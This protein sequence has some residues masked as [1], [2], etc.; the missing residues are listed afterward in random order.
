MDATADELI[1]RLRRNPDDAAAYNALRVHYHRLGDF[2]SL[3][4]L[5]EG[6]AGRT[7]DTTSAG[8][9][10]FEAGELSWGALRDQGRGM[11][12]YE[13]ALE[14]NGAHPDAF[15]RLSSL[16]EAS[17]D[18]Q[19]LAE[20]IERRADALARASADPREVAALHHRLGELWEHTFQRADKAIL[21]YRRAFELD[22]TLVPAIYA[23]REIYR[24]A[25]NLKAVATLCELEVKAEPDVE[26]RIAL[27]RELAHL[28]LES[29][30]DAEGAVTA[31]K[32]A[33][34]LD[35]GNVEVQLDLTRV[36]LAR[37]ERAQDPHLAEA[38]RRRAADALFQIAAKQPPNEAVPTLEQALDAAPD[39]EQA[40]S[41]LER[42]AER[43]GHFEL[44]PPR[45]VAFLARAAESPTAR[46]R[47]KRLAAAYAD[48]G[49]L[50]YAAQCYEWLLEEGDPEAADALVDLYRQLGRDADV[51]RA[52][53]AAARTLPPNARVPRLR[54]MMAIAIASGDPGAA[55]AHARGILEVDASDPEAFTYLETDLKK[56][57]AWGELKDLLL[58]AVRVPG[59]STDAR[60][61]RLRE[62]AQIAE[63][64]MTDVDA[65]IHAHQGI[66][67]LDPA[68][69]D[70]RTALLR[71]FEQAQRWD[72]LAQALEREVA[73]R[74]DTASQID[75][76]RRLAHVHR[77]LRSDADE[78]ISALRALRA[79]APT[80]TV[81]R[82]SLCDLLV[83]REEDQDAIPL[84]EERVGSAPAGADR[85]GLRRTLAVALERVGE[86]ERAFEAWTAL[87]GDDPKDFAALDR[88]VTIDQRSGNAERLLSTL[89]YRADLESGAERAMTLR[90]MGDIADAE[91]RDLDRAA[92]LYAR[93]LELAPSDE[94]LLDALSSAYD[95]AERY[96]DLVVLLRDRARRES[97]PSSRAALYR[98]I[99]RTL[100]D[101]VQNDDGAAEA[102]QEVLTAGEDVEA[103]SFLRDRAR[104][105]GDVEAVSGFLDRL[106]RIAEDPNERRDLLLER[107]TLVAE[108]LGRPH[109]A[110][111]IL[112]IVVREVDPSHLPALG[113]LGDLTEAV[114]DWA[115][116]AE[117]LERTLGVL[118]DPGLRVPVAQRLADLAEGE[119][120][121]R[122]RAIAA[123][124]QWSEADLMDPVPVRRLVP[125]LEAEE[126]WAPLVAALDQLAELEE[127]DAAISAVVLRAVE[128]SYRKLG[129]VDRS[130]GRL[131]PRVALGDSAA[132][133]SLRELARA[134]GRGEGLVELYV[135]LAEDSSDP[136]EQQ[137]R[138]ADAA[139]VEEQYLGRPKEALELTLKAF[140]AD[141]SE[142]KYLDEADRLSGLAGDYV[143]LGQVYETLV[144]RAE[145]KDTKVR[146]LVRHAHVLEEK[147]GD[148]GAALDRV[149]RACSLNA[150]DDAVLAFGEGLAEAAGR[151]DELLVVYDRRRKDAKDDAG[152]VEAL[153][154]AATACEERIPDRERAIHF[155]AQAVALS[156]REPSTRARIE[157]ACR[158][159][160]S[161]SEP[162]MLRALVDLYGALA[163]DMEAD[164]RA[165]AALLRSAA[166][167]FDS[168]LAEPDSAFGALLRATTI[169][170]FD[171]ESHQ[172]LT[173]LAVRLGRTGPVE[174]HL[175]RLVE[176]ALDAK[177]AGALIRRRAT[178]LARDGRHADAA[179]AW[180]QLKNLAP[181][182]EGVRVELRA[183]LRRAGKHQDLLMALG[184]ELNKAREPAAKAEIARE[185]AVTW[186][187]DLKN[188]WEAIE[189]W[190]KVLSLAPGD[191]DATEA[192]ARL[193]AGEK[194]RPASWDSEERTLEPA[195][196][197]LGLEGEGGEPND[198]PRTLPPAEDA[199]AAAGSVEPASVE[200]V[201][202]AAEDAPPDEAIAASSSDDDLLVSSPELTPSVPTFAPPPPKAVF[203]AP[204]PVE[205]AKG[206]SFEEDDDTVLGTE[207]EINQRAELSLAT[208]AP[209]DDSALL[210]LEDDADDTRGGGRRRELTPSPISPMA[211]T[212]LAPIDPVAIED[213]IDELDPA[214]LASDNAI[215]SPESL[216]SLDALLG[217]AQPLDDDLDELDGPAIEV[218][219]A[220]LR[221]SRPPPPPPPRPSTRPPS[222]GPP[223]PPRG[224]SLPPPLPPPPKK[225]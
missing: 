3:V 42:I 72:D 13:R 224:V 182:D 109:D 151:T 85:A 79:L 124:D 12:F 98:R 136:K 221:L 219:A 141:L 24:Q 123:L 99:A 205:R 80:D 71:L 117:A 35:G 82:D 4:N 143:R 211:A 220:P 28:R 63:K 49:Q 142:L 18:V 5:L 203:A 113:Q 110:I 60:K 17:G 121:D 56:R 155:V 165:G 62:V 185:I 217:D 26:R 140:A 33:I 148:P 87:L 126:R 125:L 68:D 40:L 145:D 51:M 210:P 78:A 194:A 47:R 190:T 88:M 75:L 176:E 44:L 15:G 191:A 22:A 197:Q 172:A 1:A 66:A 181:N 128:L 112:R 108:D 77:D 81:A 218:P 207:D 29:L 167:L 201:L 134:T 45:W 101:R 131:V 96:K 214:E 156:V 10:L 93:A 16:Y 202:D 53:E 122:K 193:K 171:D 83:A 69:P 154:R 222:A 32:R 158:T 25:G 163:E 188:R 50:E 178:L 120:A 114:A 103:L 11:R 138:Y 70:A 61:Q 199:S 7:T 2:A 139:G 27:L 55:A 21:H 196:E 169:A 57:G 31:L 14:Q 119:L 59:L 43:V 137:R 39:H 127:D 150:S 174:K 23:A 144:R 192:L 206:A 159:M 91:L 30:S 74:S 118:E 94:A 129:D 170:P 189:A 6:W 200:D 115:G 105:A 198:G 149:L 102:Y 37:A 168:E 153:L 216:E 89:T 41:L 52:L 204:P 157:D 64:R 92:E 186:E 152:R 166:R 195:T 179:E 209:E 208:S 67:A 8:Q 95:R 133:A 58:A 223:P 86:E 184:Q 107:A 180:A 175:G 177:T 48:A 84:L 9:A 36:Y 225:R 90:R 46:D 73:T 130:W 106:A 132:E 183:S 97:E 213:G 100:R 116:L 187:R 212:A 215:E 20:L 135:T 173:D 19:R 111:E 104:A 38:D 76:L 146:L 162:P 160:T 147:A 164:P 34:A 54:E 161:T 65:A